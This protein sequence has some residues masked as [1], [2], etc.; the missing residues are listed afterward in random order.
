MLNFCYYEVC[1]IL[2]V[3]LFILQKEYDGLMSIIQVMEV[4]LQDDGIIGDGQKKFG[5]LIIFGNYNDFNIIFL[6]I[7]VDL[8]GGKYLESIGSYCIIDC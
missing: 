7:L 5:L 4:V 3:C 2:I 6:E 1:C 8:I